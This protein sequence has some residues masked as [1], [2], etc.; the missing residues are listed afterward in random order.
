MPAIRKTIVNYRPTRT[1]PEKWLTIRDFVVD[2]IF[3]MRP[4]TAHTAL[5]TMSA[6]TRYVLWAV[7][8][9]H[10]P[11]DRADI[12]YPMMIR[13]FIN[14]VA[15]TPAS[16]Q[17]YEQRLFSI[18]TALGGQPDKARP[19]S[20][21]QLQP[22]HAYTTRHLAELDS[23]ASVRR[24]EPH[25]RAARLLIG[26]AGGA[27]VRRAEVHTIL[28]S[29]IHRKSGARIAVDIGG[30][31]PRT[32]VV[33]DEWTWY[34]DDLR[35]EPVDDRRVIFDD[36]KSRVTYVNAVRHLVDGAHPAPSLNRLRDTFVVN[37]LN[38]LP[39]ADA[40]HQVGFAT[41][42]SI[43]RYM[44]YLTPGETTR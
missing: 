22:V 34:F 35:D 12:F 5:V 23:W 6:L 14:T 11:L 26:L 33:H 31:A 13:R 1:A 21:R 10:A 42:A 41:A 8:D 15:R 27:G 28:R 29:S 43:T 3:D 16:K 7:F 36:L 24:T 18:A 2:C 4:N 38:T 25:R 19:P 17:S 30:R 32:V 39:V 44:P 40:V 37:A 20:N 9:Q